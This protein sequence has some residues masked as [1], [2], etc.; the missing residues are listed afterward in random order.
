MI[1][2]VPSRATQVFALLKTLVFFAIVP[3][4]MGGYLPYYLLGSPAIPVWTEWALREWA[5]AAAVA[6]GLGGLL[7]CGWNFAVVGL[8]TPAVWDAPKRL[9]VRGPYRWVRNPMYVAVGTAILGQSL[10]FGSARLLPYVAIFGTI[11][12]LFVVFYEEPTLREQF[13][14]DYQAYCRRVWR[15]LPLPPRKS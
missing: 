5:G 1:S 9:V 3:G 13:G 14:P 2:T 11:L 12:H 10:F 6:L 4:T 8:G 15:W 7:W